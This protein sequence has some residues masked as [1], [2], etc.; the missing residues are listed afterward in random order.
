MATVE[1]DISFFTCL[2][3]FQLWRRRA[4]FLSF[5]TTA[6]LFAELT[7]VMLFA[8][9]DITACVRYSV[10]VLVAH[11]V[12][13]ADPL[14]SARFLQSVFGKSITGLNIPPPT[15]KPAVQFVTAAEL[16]A[17]LLPINTKVLNP[18]ITDT[19][20]SKTERNATLLGQIA[21]SSQRIRFLV[22]FCAGRDDQAIVT[23]TS[24]ACDFL[25]KQLE[26]SKRRD[27]ATPAAST[28]PSGSG[29]GGG[30][31][32]ETRFIAIDANAYPE[33]DTIL[34][35]HNEKQ[36]KLTASSSASTGT[37]TAVSSRGASSGGSDA[38]ASGGYKELPP[39]T[40]EISL[41]TMHLPSVYAIEQG[42]VTRRLPLVDDEGGAQNVVMSKGNMQAFFSL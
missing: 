42:V 26:S 32:L 29:S 6:V 34:R 33:V 40:L 30:A 24:A 36:K 37:S 7:V 19:S 17:I 13:K 10:T 16:A 38:S 8:L 22:L 31:T 5:L 14:Q 41:G 39:A 25:D 15:A 35:A 11:L 4:N 27:G 12:L 18:S 9:T 1:L 23:F 28:A 2:L 21:A 20:L 3:I